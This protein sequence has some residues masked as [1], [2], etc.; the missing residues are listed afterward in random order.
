MLP[1]VFLTKEGYKKLKEELEYL[2]VAVRNKLAEKIK[3]A[4]DMGNVLENPLFDAAIDELNS[5]DSRIME[6]EQTLANHEIVSNQK[7][8]KTVTVGKEVM[9]EFNGKKDT[10]ILVSSAEA[11]PAKRMISVDSPVG[12]GLLGTSIGS[13]IEIKTPSF[14]AKYKILDIR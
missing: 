11:D 2:K 10:F 7:G 4:R 12:R 1:K 13:S 3:E 5:A 9:I 6:I 8:P 14:M